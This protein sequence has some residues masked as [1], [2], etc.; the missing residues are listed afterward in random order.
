[1]R[2][3]NLYE[4]IVKAWERGETDTQKIYDS[5][6]GEGPKW[7]DLKPELRKRFEDFVKTGDADALAQ[8]LAEYE[9]ELRPDFNRWWKKDPQEL[10]K[11]EKRIAAEDEL[12]SLMG[13][14]PSEPPAAPAKGKAKKP[15]S[16]I[17]PQKALGAP[18]QVAES[19]ARPKLENV[20]YPKTEEEIQSVLTQHNSGRYTGSPQPS[21]SIPKSSAPVKGGEPKTLGDTIAENLGTDPATAQAICIIFACYSRIMRHFKMDTLGTDLV[22]GQGSGGG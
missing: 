11:I 2:K 1:M 13:E 10:E 12:D 14:A 9:A 6:T 7:S 3:T 8:K 21:E 5:I 17:Q 15:A 18:S 16:D 4:S 19:G 20:V 22:S